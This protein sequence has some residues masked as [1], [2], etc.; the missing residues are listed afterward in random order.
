M[1]PDGMQPASNTQSSGL[2]WQSPAE[3]APAESKQNLDGKKPTVG[4][5]S[6]GDVRTTSYDEPLPNS[7]RSRKNEVFGPTLGIGER[8]PGPDG[9]PPGWPDPNGFVPPPPTNHPQPAGPSSLPI[10]E[11]IKSYHGNDAE[12]T[13]AL[14]TY[15]NF[16][17]DERL[18][19]WG[20][21]LERSDDFIRFCCHMHIWE[22][23]GS[24]GGAGESKVVWRW[25][26]IR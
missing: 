11:H 18:G 20:R 17:D 3:T 12:F 14:Q 19:G 23:L 1:D 8:G 22:M 4:S 9:M 16:R 6:N 7:P 25:T 15:F 2:K 10:L 21:Y 13:T 24:R 5:S 26:S